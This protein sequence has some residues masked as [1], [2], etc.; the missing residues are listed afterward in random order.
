MPDNVG[1]DIVP[2]PKAVVVIAP[3]LKLKFIPLVTVVEPLKVTNKSQDGAVPC[4]TYKLVVYFNA[5]P[6]GTVL[7]T[8]PGEGN[9]TVDIELPLNENTVT[10]QLFAGLVPPNNAP[11]IV[12]WSLPIYPEPPLLTVTT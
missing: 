12:I 6:T 4:L 3:V 8:T 2:P 5:L 11:E 1:A 10:V 7:P 9:V